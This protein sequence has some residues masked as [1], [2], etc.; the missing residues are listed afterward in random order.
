MI[1]FYINGDVTPLLDCD[2]NNGVWASG[3]AGADYLI[4]AGSLEDWDIQISPD[5]EGFDIRSWAEDPA[6]MLWLVM[7]K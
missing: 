5:L 7:L 2:R 1:F 3:G 6:P 4:L